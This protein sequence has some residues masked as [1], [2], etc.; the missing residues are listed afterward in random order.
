MIK[1]VASLKFYIIIIVTSFVL[2]LFHYPKN[3]SDPQCGRI[4]LLLTIKARGKF[5]STETASELY[6]CQ[7]KN[8]SKLNECL[9]Y[10]FK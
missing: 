10:K 4:L 8:E 3:I 6:F 7:N 5:C 2:V 1:Q 9:F